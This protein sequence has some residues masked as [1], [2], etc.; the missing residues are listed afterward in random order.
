[1][2]NLLS[3]A[4]SCTLAVSAFAQA[5]QVDLTSVNAVPRG[6]QVLI[7]WNPEHD[8][9]MNYHVER[10]RNG[11]D[12]VKFSDVQG[13]DQQLEF[14]ETDYTP[15]EGL[16]YYRITAT[17]ENGEELHSNIVPVKFSATGNSTS[18]V[19]ANATGARNPEDKSVLVI[20]RSKDG[21]E[22]YSKVEVE[23]EG[24]PVEVK[25]LDPA[26]AQGTYMIVG[27]SEQ[28]LYSRQLIVK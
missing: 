14:L 28:Q 22:Y 26:L 8:K 16:S 25:D 11:T 18:P 4:L 20:V 21:D 13:A 3:L 6:G 2:R 19:P 27:C 17:L 24:D 12:F 5:P 15:L 7:S 9:V 10:S 1:M 23:N